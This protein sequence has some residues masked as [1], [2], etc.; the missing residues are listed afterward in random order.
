MPNRLAGETSP[1]LLQH[2]HNPV[3]WYPWGEE[4]LQR[5][6]EEERP[7]LLSIGYSSCHWCHVMERESFEDPEIARLMNQLFVNIKVD[8]E[9]RPDLDAIY[10]QAVQAMAGQGGWPLTVFLTPEGRPFFGGTYFPPEDRGGMSGFPRV[11]QAVAQTYRERKGDVEAMAGKLLSHLSQTSSAPQGL[12]PLTADL[13]HQ[14]FQG[15]ASSFDNPRGGFGREP[16]FPQPMVYEFLLRYYHRA[17]S[18]TA[19]EMVEKS[20]QAMAH[21]GIYDQIGG[22][23]HRYSTDAF[24][25]IPHFEKMLYD[26]ALLARLYLHAHQV[27]GNGLYRRI[28][29]ETLDYVLRQMAGPEGGFYSS[30]DADSEGEEGKYYLWSPAQARGLLGDLEGQTLCRYLGVSEAGHLQGMSVLHLP[31]DLDKAAQAEGVPAEELRAAVERGRRL[32]LQE[33]SRRVPPARDE[34]VLTAW[35]G[36]LMGSLAQAAAALQ[37][38][39]YRRAAIAGATFLLDNL[40]VN[41]RLFRSYKDGQA[42]IKG[43]LEDYAFLIDGLLN[44]YEATFDYRWLQEALS[45]GRDMLELFWEEGEGLFYD[46]GRDQEALI[47]RPRDVTDNAMPSGSSMACDVLLRLGT[48]TGRADFTDKAVRALRSVQE[49]VGRHPL[50]LAHWLCALDFYLSTPKEIAIV[51][52]RDH[53]NTRAL[54][55][56]VSSLYLPNKVVAACEPGEAFAQALPLLEDKGMVRGKPTAYVCENYACQLPV[57]EAEAL[58][59][60]LGS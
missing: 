35:N 27:T 17:R 23:F 2:A 46:T 14:A 28:V 4:A 42:R 49:L 32:L 31:Q 44:L 43:Y 10:M 13:L 15:L 20:L 48:L 55:Q 56:V 36:L 16:K 45:L 22:G 8:R 12:I 21:G 58:A 9:E 34:K 38:E 6:K 3:D 53:P 1:Y 40:R 30:Q 39:D 33:R 60:Q 59:R 54:Q 19:L 37:R 50:A 29:E 25:Q 51:G 5:A 57:T 52:P 26:N 47:I 7:I 11:L 41:G 18:P 24:W